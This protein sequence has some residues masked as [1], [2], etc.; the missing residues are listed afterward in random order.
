MIYVASDTFDVGRTDY[1]TRAEELSPHLCRIDLL[2]SSD[3]LKWKKVST[4]LKGNRHFNITET[5]LVFRPDGELR[6]FT[7]Q[8]FFHVLGPPIQ[9]G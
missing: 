5:S 8:N 3:G 1:V 7:R 6:A 9:T 4:I 2:R